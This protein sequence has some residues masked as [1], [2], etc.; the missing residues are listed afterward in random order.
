AEPQPSQ[1]TQDA[2]DALAYA[3]GYT[4]APPAPQPTFD[5]LWSAWADVRGTGFDQ[6]DA[7]GQHGSQLNVTAGIGRKLTS[8][9][10]VGLFGGYENFLF[11]MAS[12]SGRMT[13]E[14]GTAGGYAAWR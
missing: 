4:K 12:I 13:G 14:G 5:R 1:R 8:D 7:N 6:T 3:A 11:S 9:F 10:L 2:F